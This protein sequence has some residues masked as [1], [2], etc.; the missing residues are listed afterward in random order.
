[1]VELYEVD[2]PDDL[3]IFSLRVRAWDEDSN[4]ADDTLDISLAGGEALTLD[5]E[6]YPVVWREAGTSNVLAPDEEHSTSGGGGGNYDGTLT[7]YL[8]DSSLGPME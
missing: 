6:V 1:M 3:G 7:F 5:Y 4:S 8:W 2:V